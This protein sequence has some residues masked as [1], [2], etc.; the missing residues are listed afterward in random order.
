M[1]DRLLLQGVLPHHIDW[2]IDWEG[3][4]VDEA[5]TFTIKRVADLYGVSIDTLRYYEEIGI[6]VPERDP[7]NGYRRYREHD[8]ERLNIIVSLL[9]MD[10]S[11][12]K[13]KELLDNHCLT[14]SL[15][16]ISFELRNLEEEIDVLIK[17]R[18]KV[19]A[20][21]L[22]LAK[23][24]HDAPLEKVQVR[25]CSQRPCLTIAP[26]PAAANDIPRIV[27]EK[28][29]EL[30]IPIDAFHS[31]PCFQL[32]TRKV[33]ENGHFDAKNIML[34]NAA[35]TIRSNTFFPA[36]KY[37]SVTFYGPVT[38]TPAVYRRLLD[39]VEGMG[40]TPVGD[41]LEFWH[42]HEY[43]SSE[44]SEYIHTLEQRVV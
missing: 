40:L 32:D 41:C 1:F 23:A 36:G 43:I 16:L 18:K 6:V 24:M 14:K 22:G 38:M 44:S 9:D 35:P 3:T 34:F 17:K 37:A 10:F 12:G 2:G 13:I 28:A 31:V 20:C 42:I 33:N 26:M 39:T 21:L 5:K 7:S 29:H 8:F 11:L 27:A 19:E 25:D 15:E 30:K 4:V